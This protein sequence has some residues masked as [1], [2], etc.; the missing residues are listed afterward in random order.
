MVRAVIFDMDGLMFDTER[1]SFRLWQEVCAEHGR[2]FTMETMA[3]LCGGTPTVGRQVFYETFGANDPD[4]SYEYCLAETRVRLAKEFEENGVPLKAGLGELLRFLQ[5]HHYPAAVASSSPTEYVRQ[6][7]QQAGL[8]H[9]FSAYVGAGD[10]TRSKPDPE[11]FL[12]A[13]KKLSSDPTVCLVLED[14]A[15][16]I[17]LAPV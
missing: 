1:L 16:G 10:F 9:Y 8:A 5:Q 12:Q 2:C 4:F 17:L 13:A 7:V 3:R 6:Y 14:S 11:C 15:R